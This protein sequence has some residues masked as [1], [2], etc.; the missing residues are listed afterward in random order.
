M[1]NNEESFLRE[2]F[3]K[4]VYKFHIRELARLTKLNPNTIIN[5]AKKL[6]NE[7]VIKKISKKHVVE[8]SLNL[9]NRKTLWKRKLF[10]LK[11]VYDSGLVNF[12][13]EKYSPSSISLIGSY[14]RGEDIENSDID[15]VIFASKKEMIDISAY[16]K[17]LRRK[18]H[19]I[20]PE[21]S[22]SEE[23]FN[24][25]INGIVLYGAIRK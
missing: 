7:G 9:E 21:K 15:F 2:L 19:L 14:S 24:N 11:Q 5:I 4:P 18:I 10:N 23:F 25:L 20:F 3:A 16:E 1:N 13:I 22:I 17:I 12:L 6:E 8:V